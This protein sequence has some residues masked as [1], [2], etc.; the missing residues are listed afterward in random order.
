MKSQAAWIDA[1]PLDTES[2]ARLSYEL[3]P[4]LFEMAIADPACASAL[5]IEATELFQRLH[6]S[7]D[8]IYWDSRNF[9]VAIAEFAEGVRAAIRAEPKWLNERYVT[10]RESLVEL[11]LRQAEY[12][13]PA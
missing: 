5:A 12:I 1:E 11:L 8:S 3:G 9:P 2:L 7:F 10:G 4:A 13:E 6:F